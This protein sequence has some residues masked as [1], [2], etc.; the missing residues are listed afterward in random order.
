M[1][2]CHNA[3]LGVAWASGPLSPMSKSQSSSS[4]ETAWEKGGTSD[5]G[6]P[7][8]GPD[9]RQMRGVPEI[10]S[11]GCFFPVPSGQKNHCTKAAYFGV[12]CA[13]LCQGLHLILIIFLPLG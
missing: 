3:G 9:F 7:G 11:L 5:R 13:E 12:P 10:L 2:V 8:G 6:V 1:Q 4:E